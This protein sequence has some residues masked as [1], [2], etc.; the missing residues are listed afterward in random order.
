VNAIARHV[1]TPCT[2]N[3]QP[4]SEARASLREG[5]AQL[6]DM[7]R[8]PQHVP[9]YDAILAQLTGL[10]RLVLRVRDQANREGAPYET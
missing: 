10:N 5:V 1:T 7:A 3:Q 2:L 4:L 9:D 6:V 8:D